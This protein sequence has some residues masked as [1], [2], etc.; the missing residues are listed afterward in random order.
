MN[1]STRQEKRK[2]YGTL[3]EAETKISTKESSWKGQQKHYYVKTYLRARAPS[4]DSDQPAHSRA[5]WSESSLS[6]FKIAKDAKFFH[7]DDKYSDQTARMRR[8]I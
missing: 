5:D 8:L 7:V 1:Y 4:E 2:R 3:T 6:A